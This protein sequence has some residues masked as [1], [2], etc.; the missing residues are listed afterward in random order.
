MEIRDTFP[1]CSIPHLAH[2]LHIHHMG[3]HAPENVPPNQRLTIR[4]GRM[5]FLSF[6]VAYLTDLYLTGLSF[7]S[8]RL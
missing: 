4:L 8:L 7:F 1:I 5:S 6:S 2:F 3:L